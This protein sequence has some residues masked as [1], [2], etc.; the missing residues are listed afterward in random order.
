MLPMNLKTDGLLLCASEQEAVLSGGYCR[1][2]VTW[3]RQN[4]RTLVIT[5]ISTVLARFLIHTKVRY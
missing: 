3:V 4:V 5:N 2:T 1:P